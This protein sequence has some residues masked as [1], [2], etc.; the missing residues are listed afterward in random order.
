MLVLSLSIYL[1][2]QVQCMPRWSRTFYYPC[3]RT[4]TVTWCVTMSS[5]RCPTRPTPWLA[6]QPTSPSWTLRFSWKSSSWWQGSSFFSSLARSE[7][8]TS[9]QTDVF[10]VLF[11]FFTVLSMLLE[12]KQNIS[13]LF[14]LLILFLFSLLWM[15]NLS[16]LFFYCHFFFFWMFYSLLGKSNLLVVFFSVLFMYNDNFYYFRLTIHSI[17]LSFAELEM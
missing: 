1:C 14:L 5:M 16:F 10:L 12:V 15:W 2:D 13:V 7:V 11:F 8:N 4:K 17:K 9:L 6:G 3:F